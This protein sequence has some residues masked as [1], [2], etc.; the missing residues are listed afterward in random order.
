LEHIN[1][2]VAPQYFCRAKI[3]QQFRLICLATESD[4]AVT[5]QSASIRLVS[6]I[7]LAHDSCAKINNNIK[8]ERYADIHGINELDGTG[9]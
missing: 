1:L 6:A 9:D 5:A 8:G 7:N 3:L 4:R 2:S